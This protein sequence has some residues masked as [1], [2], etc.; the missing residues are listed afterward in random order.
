MP[1]SEIAQ[2]K[3]QQAMQEQAALQGL[4][5]FATHASHKVITARMEQAAPYLVQLL[6]PHCAG[7]RLSAIVRN[8]AIAVVCPRTLLYR[9]CCHLR[10]PCR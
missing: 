7:T 8:P 4:N 9:P 6:I 2:F 3:Q 10:D 1:G 5:G